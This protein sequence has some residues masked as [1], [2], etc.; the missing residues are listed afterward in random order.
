MSGHENCLPKMPGR[1]FDFTPA[2]VPGV[3]LQADAPVGVAPLPER[4]V[5]ACRYSLVLKCPSCA[6]AIPLASKICPRCKTPITVETAV[7]SSLG[8]AQRRW[9]RWRDH[10]TPQTKWRLKRVL[11]WT[12][13]LTYFL[14]SAALLRRLL[15]SLAP[16]GIVEWLAPAALSVLF[17]AALGVLLLWIV[18]RPLIREIFETAS[19]LVKVSLVLNYLSLLLFLQVVVRVWWQQSLLVGLLLVMSCLGFWL[20]RRV[21]WPGVKNAEKLFREGEG[22][23][24]DPSNPQGRQADFD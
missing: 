20:L 19:R 16:W 8:P 21:F 5:L 18:P 17:L 6:D 10:L 24:F 9:R 4:L 13:Q 14:G 15:A 1:V 12:C 23:G 11:A 22:K 3:W 7:H 2:Q